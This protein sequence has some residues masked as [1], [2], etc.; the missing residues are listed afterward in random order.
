MTDAE[1]DRCIVWLERTDHAFEHTMMRHCAAAIRELRAEMA[2]LAST[3]GYQKSKIEA[4]Q[5]SVK[6]ALAERDA[7]LADAER[8]VWMLEVGDGT[9]APLMRQWNRTPNECRA[10]I[11]AARKGK[12]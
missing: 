8:F 1:L 6:S 9:Y 3:F 10:L 12:A 11:D 4:L 5:G 7:A 2:I